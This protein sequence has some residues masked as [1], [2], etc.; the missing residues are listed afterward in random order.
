MLFVTFVSFPCG[1]SLYAID[2]PVSLANAL[3]KSSRESALIREISIN[4]NSYDHFCLGDCQCHC[5]CQCHRVLIGNVRQIFQD[6]SN[7][8][9]THAPQSGWEAQSGIPECTFFISNLWHVDCFYTVY[10]QFRLLVR[11]WATSH[12]IRWK[13]LDIA[14]CAS[15]NIAASS[16]KTGMT[17]NLAPMDLPINCGS[18]Q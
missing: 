16:Y 12:R 9:A 4:R 2:V 3:Q 17:A 6:M 15:A 14:R 11:G 10:K 18:I 7:N 13:A 1:F 5:Q 8:T